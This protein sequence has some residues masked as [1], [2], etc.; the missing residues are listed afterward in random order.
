MTRCLIRFSPLR[1][2][3]LVLGFEEMIIKFPGL[4]AYSMWLLEKFPAAKD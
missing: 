3:T 4:H 2:N 1:N